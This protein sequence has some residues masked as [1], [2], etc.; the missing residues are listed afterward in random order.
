MESSKINA[1]TAF[2]RKVLF[3]DR[4]F[5]DKGP[6]FQLAFIMVYFEAL[7]AEKHCHSASPVSAL[8]AHVRRFFLSHRTGRFS[9]S[10]LLSKKKD[11]KNLAANSSLSV[12][13]WPELLW[14]S[15]SMVAAD[16]SF[17]LLSDGEASCISPSTAHSVNGARFNSAE[18]WALIWNTRPFLKL[19]EVTVLCNLSDSIV[20]S[21]LLL[22]L[23]AY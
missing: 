4:N 3:K 11:E 20:Y 22:Q 23:L 13:C 15:P 8:R 9:Q 21:L 6:W 16:S 1:H 5:W 2:P 10:S 7:Y 17:D 18:R 14:L 12:L 19:R